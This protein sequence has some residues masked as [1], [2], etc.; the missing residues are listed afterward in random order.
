MNLEK[1][2]LILLKNG[3]IY[4]PS[5]QSFSRESI[6][7]ENGVVS[8]VSRE[9]KMPNSSKNKGLIVD[10]T[11]KII[12]PGFVDINSNIDF[13]DRPDRETLES[14][15]MAS[16][17]GGYTKVCISPIQSKVYDTPEAIISFLN[18]VDGNSVEF[19]PFGSP[20]KNCKGLELAEIGLMF[21][22]GA[23]G[24]S[25]GKNNLENTLMLRYILQ[26]LKSYQSTF[27]YSC[28][29]K[30]LSEGSSINEGLTST[31]M[32]VSSSPFISETIDAYRALS[33][34]S[35]LKGQIHLSSITNFETINLIENFSDKNFFPTF[36]ISVHN[37]FFSD[38]DLVNF[39]TN[40]KSESLFRSNKNRK[41]IINY[42]NRGKINCISSNHR[43]LSPDEKEKDFYSSLSGFIS[44]QTSFALACKSV[45]AN[46]ENIGN[47]ID[48]FTIG[49]SKILNLPINFLDEKSKANFAIIDLKKPWEFNRDVSFSKSYNTPLEKMNFP[50]SI[51]GTISGNNIYLK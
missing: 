34:A 5:T 18:K 49:P 10:C 46:K 25:N 35:Y 39:D 27:M 29:D 47:I 40:L 42:L 51:H 20:T 33:L 38:E 4:N 37:L 44:L 12:C 41:R 1:Y 3:E 24:I 23:I 32:G 26:Y 9:I 13:F 28:Y 50:V 30:Y 14:A 48:C 7:I 2:N 6:L 15:T 36:D 22:A 45:N 16:M 43:P 31:R 19:L 11:N 8:K 21:K 17:S